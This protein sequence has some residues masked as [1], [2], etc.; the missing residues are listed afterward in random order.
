MRLKLKNFRRHRNATFTLPEEGLVALSG[1]K[2][3]GKST[4][5]S[6]ISFAFFG[7]CPSK[8]RRKTHSHGTT[9]GTVK[10]ELEY[11]RF[12]LKIVRSSKKNLT[13]SLMG[14]DG[15]ERHTEGTAA[16]STI[17]SVLGMSYE[18]FLVSSYIYQGAETSV[19]SMT[20]TEQLRFV[21]ILA[22]QNIEVRREQLKKQVKEWISEKTGLEGR[23]EVLEDALAEATEKYAEPPE[24]PE[25]ERDLE[26]S[27][28]L[29]EKFEAKRVRLLA[30]LEEANENL[31]EARRREALVR[32]TTEK[33]S[34]V[35]TEIRALEKKI[36]AAE[37][38]ASDLDEISARVGVLEK[39]ALEARKKERWLEERVSFQTALAE[40]VR[41]VK[42]ELKKFEVGALSKDEIEKLGKKK[43]KLEAEMEIFSRVRTEW[44][45]VSTRRTETKLAISKIFAQIRK[46]FE[47]LPGSRRES[48]VGDDVRKPSEMIASLAELAKNSRREPFPKKTFRCP[49]CQCKCSVVLDSDDEP[50]LE[51]FRTETAGEK[52]KKVTDEIP[53]PMWTVKLLEL[54]R[55]LAELPS[56][57]KPE[58]DPSEKLELVSKKLAEAVDVSKKISG[59]RRSLTDLPFALE[60]MRCRVEESETKFGDDTSPPQTEKIAKK[61]EVAKSELLKAR[62]QHEILDELRDDLSGKNRELKTLKK[63]LDACSVGSDGAGDDQTQTSKSQEVKI[64]T[65]VSKLTE[66]S[67]KTSSLRETIDALREYEN[68]LEYLESKSKLERETKKTKRGL[69]AIEN[70]LVGAKGFEETLKEAQILSLQKTISDINFHA[71]TYLDQLFQEPISVRLDCVTD[72]G[73]AGLKLAI[74]TKV[75]YE[76]EIYDDVCEFSGGEAQ[77]CEVAFLLGVNEMKNSPIIMLDECLNS[78]GNP[79]NQDCLQTIKETLASSGKVDPK[80]GMR[81]PGKLI[82]VVAHEAIRGIF[83]EE[84]IITR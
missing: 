72:R 67:T 42:N 10:V 50:V 59:L 4:I 43:T 37:G 41:E 58:N 36:S 26:Q 57:A 1:K 73:K 8:K 32:T 64:S 63:K 76:D 81:A 80:T 62:H 69:Q 30:D 61:L 29:A 12:G 52:K 78:L 15:V 9:S 71:K 34:V 48:E 84:V 79:F 3:S 54:S 14:D 82:L 49:G 51:K 74:N 55:V 40:H 17:C 6:A 56:V 18:E 31:D 13:V 46:K 47:I 45:F 25:S 44:D 2:G 66:L 16:Q 19:L 20:P 60:R 75:E 7:V 77:Q 35:T 70:L 22:K 65:I 11:E 68:Y 39:K 24:K 27:L 21:E 53:D 33:I 38:E 23:L 83:D 5:L 28:S